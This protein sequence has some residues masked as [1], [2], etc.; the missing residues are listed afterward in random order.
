[1]Q[2]NEDCLY[3]DLSF[4]LH[5]ATMNGKHSQGNTQKDLNDHQCHCENIVFHIPVTSIQHVADKI[6]N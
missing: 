6:I 4:L 3:Q 1:M 5:K 2:Q